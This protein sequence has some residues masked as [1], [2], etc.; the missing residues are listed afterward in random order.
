MA[1]KTFLWL[2]KVR[3]AQFFYHQT[4]R[5]VFLSFYNRVY[6]TVITD[7]L[8]EWNELDKLFNICQAEGDVSIVSS[9]TMKVGER[10]K[11]QTTQQ[12][13][14]HKIDGHY[15]I[16]FGILMTF[17]KQ[18]WQIMFKCHTLSWGRWRRPCNKA[19]AVYNYKLKA[20]GSAISQPAAGRLQEAVRRFRPL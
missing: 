7:S 13:K 2:G 3:K 6:N 14:L 12:Q 15:H 17:W 4:K 18:P 10:G 9:K 20:V 8:S 1:Q 19:H 16:S 5:I 11:Q